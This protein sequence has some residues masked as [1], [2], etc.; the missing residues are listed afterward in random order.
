[1]WKLWSK[2]SYPE[3]D[4]SVTHQR[5][6]QAL[7]MISTKCKIP[8]WPLIGQKV[9]C[10][11]IYKW[12]VPTYAF[13][14]STTEAGWSL[15][16]RPRLQR[17]SLIQKP[18]NQQTNK[19]QQQQKNPLLWESTAIYTNSSHFWH[20]N[21]PS[22]VHTQTEYSMINHLWYPNLLSLSYLII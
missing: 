15:S 21:R 13:N 2:G 9:Q 20:S 16:S 5:R 1:M 8:V 22:W 10:T 19:E 4:H 3:C 7:E 14:P 6:A 17:E 11:L 18:N 12:V